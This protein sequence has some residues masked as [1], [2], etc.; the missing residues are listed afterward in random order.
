[1]QNADQGGPPPPF[2]QAVGGGGGGGAVPQGPLGLVNMLAQ[3]IALNQ[4]LVNAN[5]QMGQNFQML[6]ANVNQLNHP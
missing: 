5:A 2:Q 4:Q 3:L 1:M 6:E